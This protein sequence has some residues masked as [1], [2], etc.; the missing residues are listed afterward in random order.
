V[1][2]WLLLGL[3]SHALMRIWSA[4]DFIPKA[5]TFERAEAGAV[6][7][8]EA[9][10]WARRSLLRLPLDLVTCA[11]MLAAFATAVRLPGA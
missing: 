7:E 6:T 4:L 5:L 1:R 9:R 10:A 2:S 11:A 8:T 3:V